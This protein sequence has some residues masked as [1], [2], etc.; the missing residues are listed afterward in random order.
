MNNIDNKHFINLIANS[1]NNSGNYG[2]D[3]REIENLERDEKIRRIAIQFE[4]ILLENLLK[5][6]F[7]EEENNESSKIFGNS[8]NALKDFKTMMLSQYFSESGG[9]GYQEV[10]ERQ[11]KEKLLTDNN[12]SNMKRIRESMNF[13]EDGEIELPVPPTKITSPFGY[14]RDPIDGKRRFHAGIDLR[15][16]IGTPVKSIMSGEVIYSGWKKGYGNI[17][18]I[19]HKNGIETKYAH[20][21]K[22]LINSGDRVNAGDTIALSGSSGRSTGPHLHFEVLKDGKPI[23]PLLFLK[24][25]SFQLYKKI[26][27]IN[28]VSV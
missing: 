10:I 8:F 25:K 20:N 14:R 27:E 28:N 2:I 9:L 23:N 16:K 6:A 21:S 19:R 18:V 7:K 15:V 3:I 17:I 13:I 11:I 5:E 12:S 26:A 22:I 24:R 4:Q 1:I